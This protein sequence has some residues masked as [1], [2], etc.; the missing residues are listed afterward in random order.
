MDYESIEEEGEII[1]SGAEQRAAHDLWTEVVMALLQR[2][3]VVS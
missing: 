2:D 1:P 3:E